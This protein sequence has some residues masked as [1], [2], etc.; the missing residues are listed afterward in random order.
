M[1]VLKYIGYRFCL[2]LVAIFFIFTFTFVIIRATPG[3]PLVQ[4]KEIPPETRRNLEIK[5]GLDK[6]LYIQYAIQFKQV[7]FHWDFG[8]SFRIIGKSV[9][10]II[11]EQFPVSASIGLLSSFFGIVV[12]VC[13]GS[14]AALYHGSNLDRFN[15]LICVLGTSL[16]SYI[17][18]YLFQY[19]FAVIPLTVLGFSPKYWLRAGGWGEFRDLILPSLTLSLSVIASYARLMRSQ[20]LEVSRADFIKTATAKGISPTRIFFFHKMRNSVLP[21]VSLLPTTLVWQMT[22]SIIIENIFGIPGL[23]K[24]YLNAIQSQDYNVIMGMTL[25]IGIAGVCAYFLTDLLYGF[26]DPRIRVFDKAAN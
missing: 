13:L 9:N 18:A 21:L 20:L 8:K 16:P 17:F 14:C 23:G 4:L 11:K 19:L 24:A 15:M 7:F 26:I 25:F 6:P 12:G 22:G 10:E 5:Y 1:D 3:D 2:S